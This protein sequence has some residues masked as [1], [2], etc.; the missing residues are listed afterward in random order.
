MYFISDVRRLAVNIRDGFRCGYCQ[1]NLATLRPRQMT[2]D[3][4]VPRSK[5]GGHHLSNLVTCCLSCNSRK[6]DKYTWQQFCRLFYPDALRRIYNLKRRVANIALAESYTTGRDRKKA[7][8]LAV[9][10]VKRATPIR[11]ARGKAGARA[12]R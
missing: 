2:L 5:G 1:K 3:H 12:V 8:R 11:S 7:R 9:R 4:L 10:A 6:Q